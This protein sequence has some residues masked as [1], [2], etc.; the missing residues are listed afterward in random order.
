MSD[1][2][3]REAT[4]QDVPRIVE[5]GSQFLS[6]GPYKGELEENPIQVLKCATEFLA[7][8][9]MKILVAQEEGS[10]CGVF[11][12]MIYTH[13]FSGQLTAV[14]LIWYVDPAHRGRASMELLWAAERM[15]YEMGAKWFQL[16]APSTETAKVYERLKYT[17][18]ETSYQ[19][20]LENRV[21]H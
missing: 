3:V 9:S 7:H 20:R 5:L 11:A 1:L 18:I 6:L 10:V 15:A 21:R 12:M 2:I 17:P 19:A 8:P 13:P 4:G 14:E 16:T